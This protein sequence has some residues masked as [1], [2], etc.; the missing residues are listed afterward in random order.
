MV[1]QREHVGP[2]AVS[3][4]SMSDNVVAQPGHQRVSRS[5]R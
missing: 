1:P 5:A 3:F 4:A 2:A